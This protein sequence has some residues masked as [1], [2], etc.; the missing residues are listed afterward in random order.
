MTSKGMCLLALTVSMAGSLSSLGCSSDSATPE[1]SGDV[2]VFSWWTNG[3]EK[4]ALQAVIDLNHT[5]YPKV[6]VTNAAVALGD[7]ARDVLKQRMST[8]DP[9]DL[10]QANIG[11]DL[12]QWAGAQPKIEDLTSIVADRNF[13]PDLTKDNN[14]SQNGALYGMPVNIHRINSL[15]IN[16]PVL[17]RNGVDPATLNTLTGLHTALATLKADTTLYAPMTIGSQYKWT[18]DILVLETLLPAVAGGQFYEDYYRGNIAGGTDPNI[19]KMLDEAALLW[20]YMPTGTHAPNVVDWVPAIQD[21]IDGHV[22]M[23]VMGDWA[24][25]LIDATPATGGAIMVAGTDYDEIPFPSADGVAGSFVYTTDTFA[26]PVGAKNRDLAIDFLKTFASDEGQVAF[27]KAKG[28]IPALPLAAGPRGGF[29]AVAQRTMAAFEDTSTDRRVALS[30]IAT[31]LFT[32]PIDTA[33]QNFTLSCE[34]GAC[35]QTIVTTALTS[36]Y[37]P[38]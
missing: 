15:F 11:K 26:L 23:T 12:L 32:D 27:N 36:N 14:L 5:T 2:E 20:T 8:G 30:G 10:F 28:S 16:L 6:T 33:L 24:K 37:P 29:D 34:A 18:L 13:Y 22:A 4:Q 19:G 38:R 25:G 7:Q 17:Q 9:P 3:G 31:N 21:F 1:K 35:D